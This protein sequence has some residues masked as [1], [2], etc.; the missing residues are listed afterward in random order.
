MDEKRNVSRLDRAR[1]EVKVT[2]FYY[3]FRYG[4]VSKI[5]S[6]R[7]TTAS[8]LTRKGPLF[9]GANVSSA[10]LRET[11]VQI[12]LMASQIY[13]CHNAR[14][15][16]L[17]IA[18]ALTQML[19]SCEEAKLHF[20][21]SVQ[22]EVADSLW[23]HGEMTASIRMLQGINKDNALEK[24]TIPVN[25]SELLSKMSQRISIARFEKPR[26]IQKKYLEPA[27][28]ELKRGNR[29]AEVAGS[30]YHQFATF[31]DEQLQDADGLEDLDRLQRLRKK[32]S[33]EVADLKQLVAATKD[34]QLRSKYA[35]VLSKEKQWLDLDEQELLRVEQTR[36]EFVRLSLENYLHSLA[37]SDK[38]DRDA[39][40]F[41]ALW[42]ERSAEEQT[43]QSVGRHLSSVATRKFAGLM[44]QLTS[45]LQCQDSIFQGLLMGLVYNICVDHPYHGMYQIWSGAKAKV[46]QT[47]EVAVLRVKAT[48]QVA[49]RLASTK[50]VGSIWQSIDK[51]SKYYHALAMDRQP[52]R[53]KCGAKI[54]LKDSGA[55]QN[56]V[57][58]LLKYRIPP[59]TMQIEL[60]V[61][62]DYSEVVLVAKMKPTMT[63]AS[64][65][66]APKIITAIGSDGREYKQLVKGGQDDL[67]QD[68]IMEQVFAAVSSLLKLHRSTR[69][70][71]LGI[72]TYKVLPLTAS[73]GVIEF[74]AN[75]IPLHD[76]LMPAHERYHGRDLTGSQCRREIFGVQSS[77]VERRVSTYRRV[78]ERFQPVLRYFFMEYFVDP[79]EWFTRRTAYTR[80]TAV[81]SILGHVLG[82]GD[83][84]GHNILLDKKTGEAVHIDLGVAFEA[85]RILPVPEVVPFRLTRDVVDGMGISKTEGAFRR[86]CE[87]TLDALR[88]EQY[89]IMTI[90]DVLR[91][92][93]LYTW[94]IS[95]LRLA[96]LQKARREDEAAAAAVATATRTT[97][98]MTTSA[99]ATEEG[100]A[101]GA[102]AERTKGSTRRA[103]VQFN[104][105]SEADR[106]LEIV[107]KK[108]SKTLSVTATV[109][110]LINQASDERNLALMY[111]GRSRSDLCLAA[112][113]LGG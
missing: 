78:A 64:G 55:G 1:V 34:T 81:I 110:E 109:N 96:K 18:T 92:D 19:P 20:E 50:A 77:P 87:V 12:M 90:L 93:P 36:S 112:A 45:R 27:L 95:P 53:Y 111:S 41:T 104:E 103:G 94:S 14:Q 79:D 49:Q 3:Y 35:H 69:Q 44:N 42:L 4:D 40:R 66:S 98:R 29:G 2:L 58:S 25:R 26:D 57:N 28:K 11:Q 23:D 106:A 21:A 83:R 59:P 60:S 7:Q 54:A 86:C 43:N 65:V 101:S 73:S 9:N 47:D 102:E 82:L 91:Y 88:E 56:L 24:Q 22:I 62:K 84:H 74:V 31:C 76:F 38:H 71:K 105:P 63:I 107:R 33:D 61:T 13:R 10:S 99:T 67:R 52:N 30:V 72:R 8:V 37:A 16:T 32:K 113:R 15:E 85:G 6:C 48:E 39:L 80:S 97:T 5:L 100:E 68:A 70:R 75:T 51:T 17:N 108:L 46:Q 89:S